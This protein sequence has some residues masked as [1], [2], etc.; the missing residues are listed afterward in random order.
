MSKCDVCCTS[1]PGAQTYWLGCA[2]GRRC[3]VPCLAAAA[4]I[5]Y[6]QTGDPQGWTACLKCGELFTN[7][8]LVELLMKLWAKS[9]QDENERIDFYGV[10]ATL[11]ERRGNFA[12]AAKALDRMVAMYA[13]GGHTLA[14][15]RP[16]LDA[17]RKF[18][19]TA[20]KANCPRPAIYAFYDI[21]QQSSINGAWLGG[22]DLALVFMAM[23]HYEKAYLAIH[24]SL[25]FKAFMGADESARFELALC[26]V[27]LRTFR[28]CEAQTLAR[29]A[30]GVQW[31]A[32][33]RMT[34]D[35]AGTFAKAAE[36]AIFCF[37][38]NPAAAKNKNA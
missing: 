25:K 11:F 36:R 12:E 15:S 17:K 30:D 22:E 4:Q 37:D 7:A 31:T 9:L 5:H 21:L 34:G 35:V 23:G 20:Y 38:A 27:C 3:H 10:V 24:K 1:M 28:F 2:C 29:G 33:S 16:M 32:Q 8:P 13:N 26:E 14:T 19:R 6:K 18:A